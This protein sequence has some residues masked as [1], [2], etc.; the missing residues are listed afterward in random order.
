MENLLSVRDIMNRYQC[1]RDTA[2]RH[3][4]RMEH[5]EKPYMVTESAV[6]AYESRKTVKPPEVIR[7]E[8]MERLLD[9]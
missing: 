2:I 6:M 3:I 9:R 7:A 1:N 5:M 4:R 8:M